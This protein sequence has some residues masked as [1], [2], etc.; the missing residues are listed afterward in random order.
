MSGHSSLSDV[1]LAHDDHDSLPL[2]PPPTA[3]SVTSLNMMDSLPPPPPGTVCHQTDFVDFA[4]GAEPCSC[5]LPG[6]LDA[7]HEAKQFSGIDTPGSS[8]KITFDE[9][10]QVIHGEEETS[11]KLI[12]ERDCD[13]CL[14]ENLTNKWC[15]NKSDLYDVIGRRKTTFKT[16][17]EDVWFEEDRT[18]SQDTDPEQ[19]W[20]Q[21]HSRS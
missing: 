7:K 17:F 11:Q 14:E 19:Y 15:L 12:F 6:E 8:K 1:T 3:H 5:Q 2:P 10:V 13:E 16:F 20:H 18:S 4:H 21:G 9:R